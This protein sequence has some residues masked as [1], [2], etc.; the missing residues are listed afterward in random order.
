MNRNASV[1]QV[2]HYAE[3]KGYDARC[4]QIDAREGRYL[5]EPERTEYRK[6]AE[7]ERVDHRGADGDDG[8]G[9]EGNGTDH[10]TRAGILLYRGYELPPQ[11]GGAGT[12]TGRRQ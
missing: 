10:L 5:S 7:E 4:R 11:C 2:S 9:Q 8:A 1:P 3:E 6:T 12:E